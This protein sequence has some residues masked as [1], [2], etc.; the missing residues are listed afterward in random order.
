[1]K[2]YNKIETLF[3]RD[4]EGSKK[5]IFGSY[6]NETVEFL[7]DCQWQFTEK[8]DGT[9]IDI[10]YKDVNNVGALPK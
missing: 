5:L 3:N 2:E 7:K 4:L 10:K 1:M 9:N 8:N 6:R